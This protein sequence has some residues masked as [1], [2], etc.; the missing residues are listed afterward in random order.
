M[1]CDE[2]PL[3]QRNRPDVPVLERRGSAVRP[4]LRVKVVI[5]GFKPV[6]TNVALA[7]W[8]SLPMRFR[9]VEL[10]AR[11]GT[12]LAP[13]MANDMYPLP[14][15]VLVEMPAVTVTSTLPD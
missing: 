6:R 11:G 1:L 14:P 10:S 3:G 8:K 12:V 13:V 7:F 2:E 5:P 4:V 15:P 9:A